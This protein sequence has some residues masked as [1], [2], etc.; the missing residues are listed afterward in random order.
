LTYYVLYT[1]IYIK[2]Y[3]ITLRKV[4]QYDR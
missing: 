4:K 2:I 1:I 3:D